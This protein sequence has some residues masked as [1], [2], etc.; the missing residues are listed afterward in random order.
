MIN[1]IPIN[2]Q[3]WKVNLENVKFPKNTHIDDWLETSMKV[4]FES[5]S[6]FSRIPET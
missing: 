3:E 6:T 5:G 2:E 1:W 4:E